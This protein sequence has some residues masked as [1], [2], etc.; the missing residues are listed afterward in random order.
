MKKNYRIGLF[1]A[2]LALL[3]VVL[4]IPLIYMNPVSD[5]WMLYLI[6]AVIC[7][8]MTFL[9]LLALLAWR[10]WLAFQTNAKFRTLLEQKELE[11]SSR[12]KEIAGLKGKLAKVEA[13]I[14]KVKN[15]PPKI[16][17][18]DQRLLLLAEKLRK[19]TKRETLDGNKTLTTTEEVP[20]AIQAFIV[21][22]FK[23]FHSPD[24]NEEV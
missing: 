23:S 13:E 4:P 18:Q 9:G 6:T 16:L 24:K 5:G 15:T 19:T 7:T 8:S 2:L 12:I 11:L 22:Q 1:L 20:E 10:A 3:V 17:D 14:N 21:E